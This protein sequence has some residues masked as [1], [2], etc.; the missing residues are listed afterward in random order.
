MA[1]TRWFRTPLSRGLWILVRNVWLN[2]GGSTGVMIMAITQTPPQVINKAIEVY[3]RY[4]KRD[5]IGNS[6]SNQQISLK[7]SF[8]P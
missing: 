1:I 5:T 3:W 7:C 2:G 4:V 6:G 8:C